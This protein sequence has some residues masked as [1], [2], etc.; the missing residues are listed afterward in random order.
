MPSVSARLGEHNVLLG[1]RREGMSL[2]HGVL[3]LQRGYFDSLCG[4]LNW[5]GQWADWKTY[6]SAKPF[7]V[8]C[9]YQIH[10][11][12]AVCCEKTKGP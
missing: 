1:D 4:F 6:D 9:H 10:L 5:D 8:A 11:R 12:Y 2:T 7:S 3:V